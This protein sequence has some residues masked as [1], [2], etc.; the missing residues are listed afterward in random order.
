MF[1]HKS[2]KSTAEKQG[3]NVKQKSGLNRSILRQVWGELVRQIEYKQAWNGGITIAVDPKYT[4]Q[5]CSEY[6]H[7]HKDNRKSQ[8]NFTCLACGHHENADRNA[9]KNIL[10]AGHAVLACGET[11]RPKID[12]CNNMYL[13]KASSLKQEPFYGMGNQPTLGNLIL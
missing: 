7:I 1:C 11:V 12:V 10:A 13:F 9:A 2:A 8:S 3:K 4:S 6:G 5:K